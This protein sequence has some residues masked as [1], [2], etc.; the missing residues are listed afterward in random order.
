MT[1][2]VASLMAL[3]FNTHTELLCSV[4]HSNPERVF[5]EMSIHIF[6]SVIFA[7]I[8]FRTAIFGCCYD[9]LSYFP[10]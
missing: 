6:Q 2:A 8:F 3:L 1:V 7:G 10:L 5:I 4:S 9:V